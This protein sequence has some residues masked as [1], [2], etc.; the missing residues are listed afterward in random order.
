[1]NQ[2]NLLNNYKVVIVQEKPEDLELHLK[3]YT[4]PF[5]LQTED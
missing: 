3:Q 4:I 2:D 5:K 1:M